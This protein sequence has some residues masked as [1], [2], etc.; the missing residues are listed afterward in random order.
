MTTTTKENIIKLIQ[1][2]PEQVTIDDI[3]YELYVTQSIE[4]GQKDI[5][6]GKTLST[7]EVRK[8]LFRHAG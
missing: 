5:A 3:M 7:D 8:R 1:G 6:E 2:L 4:L